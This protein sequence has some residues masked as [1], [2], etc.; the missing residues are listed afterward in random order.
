MAVLRVVIRI[1]NLHLEGKQFLSGELSVSTFFTC[2]DA[3]I[4]TIVPLARAQGY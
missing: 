1:R 2:F 3:T 4:V